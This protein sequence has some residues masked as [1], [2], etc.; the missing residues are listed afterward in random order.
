MSDQEESVLPMQTELSA[1]GMDDED[2]L[3]DRP[4]PA[5]PPEDAGDPVGVEDPADEPDQTDRERSVKAGQALCRALDQLLAYAQE[6]RD[7]AN[8][9]V[10]SFAAPPPSEVEA[11]EE[12][13]N[14]TTDDGEP[15]APV[16]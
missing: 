10:E 6:A 13:E 11:E 9:L 1:L 12:P 16:P 8:L 15:D 5:I 4:Q 3:K 14:Q 7:A 2:W